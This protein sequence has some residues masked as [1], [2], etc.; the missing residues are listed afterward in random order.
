MGGQRSLEFQRHGVV[1]ALDFQ[2]GETARASLEITDLLTFLVRKSK[3]E[4]T[5]TASRI[6]IDQAAFMRTKVD[7]M[8]IVQQAPDGT[9]LK[10]DELVLVIKYK[11]T[12]RFFPIVDRRS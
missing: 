8:W 6:K 10:V 2:R 5:P 9:G 7:Q 4:M 1:S 3:H 11:K 12:V